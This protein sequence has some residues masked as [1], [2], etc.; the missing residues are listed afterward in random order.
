M[1][2][3]YY[4]NINISQMNFRKISDSEQL[5]KIKSRMES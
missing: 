5:I 2:R 3:K 1:F 4:L